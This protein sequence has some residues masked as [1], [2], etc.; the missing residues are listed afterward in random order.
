MLMVTIT[1]IAGVGAAA[2]AGQRADGATAA[3]Y[4]VVFADGIDADAK[5]SDLERTHGFR[6]DHRFR[7]SLVGFA[8]RLSAR[9]RDAIARDPAVTYYTRTGP[10][11]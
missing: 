8:A 10:C 11:A 6:A 3:P 7:S 9:Q 4:I 1:V 2:L 5:T